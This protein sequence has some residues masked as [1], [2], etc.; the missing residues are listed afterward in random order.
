MRRGHL[1]GS[2]T[3]AVPRGSPRGWE[4]V[5]KRGGDQGGLEAVKE[6]LPAVRTTGN[7]VDG[8]AVSKAD[9]QVGSA[10]EICKIALKMLRSN[11]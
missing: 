1:K 7:S 6:Q 8:E 10:R 9:R 4:A 11:G 2:S 3:W 5:G